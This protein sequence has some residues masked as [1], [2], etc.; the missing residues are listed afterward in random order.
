MATFVDIPPNQT[1]YVN[2]LTEKIKLDELK[3]SLYALFSQFGPI[4]EIVA[5]KSRKMRGQAFIVF[6]DLP[7][8]TDALQ[9]LQ[10]FPFYDRPMK[11][12]YAKE[13]SEIIGIIEGKEKRKGGGRTQGD[14]R[15]ITS[16][17]VVPKQEKAVNPQQDHK[18]EDHGQH[19]SQTHE[20]HEEE[21]E[22][23]EDGPSMKLQKI[24]TA[25]ASSQV[26]NNVLFV[27]NLPDNTTAMML[28][29][30][31]QQFQGF[32]EVRLANKQGMAFVEYGNDTQAAA[33]MNAL[34]DFKITEK[35]LMK[36]SYAK[37]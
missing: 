24:D 25:T 5:L 22:E 20:E 37:K 34:Q 8:A 28:S 18:M 35:N 23:T 10:G 1:L 31:F 32:V 30:L 12:S 6:K 11:I 2:S 17:P 33:A 4:I 16:A 13:Q 3:R 15:R 7:A 29:A 27:E 36:I 26:P 14:K 9:R 19:Y 21:E